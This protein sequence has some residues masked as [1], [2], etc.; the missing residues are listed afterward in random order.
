MLPNNLP[1]F[2]KP[3]VIETVLGLQFATLPNF[4][5]AHL[6]SFW[7]Y[8]N[9]EEWPHAND[10]PAIEP[11]FERFGE[12]NRGRVSRLM[13]K[14]VSEIGLRMQIRNAEKNRM[15]QLQNGRLHYNWLG[16]DGGPYPSFSKVKLEFDKV[17]DSFRNYLKEHGFEDLQLNQ[18]EITY[19]NHIPQGSIW[20]DP[21]DWQDIFPSMMPFAAKASSIK[22]ESLGG[23][24]HYE[25][26]PQKGRLHINISHGWQ[27]ELKDKEVLVLNLTARGPMPSTNT[28]S[29]PI[30]E[31][32]RIGHEAIVR[33]FKELTSDKAHQ[34]WEEI[35]D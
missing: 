9:P 18:W 34:Y 1:K 25:I 5:T 4:G 15:I 30:D 22:L 31:G 17:F 20:S 35:H 11:Q 21:Q 14:V 7:Q 33:S 10:A 19:I 16:L 8:Y 12:E 26:E 23:E 27:G 3:P 6:G 13:F 29:D 28:G 32:F 24:W 2:R